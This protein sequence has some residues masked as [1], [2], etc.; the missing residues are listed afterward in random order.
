MGTILKP[1]IQSSTQSY[2]QLATQITRIA[3]FLGA[4]R[5]QIR[6][7]VQP[8]PEVHTQHEEVVK[9]TIKQEQEIHHV[10]KRYLRLSN[11]LP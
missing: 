10:S 8:Q 5:A 1:L 6:L 9:V 2:Q 11:I 7:I 3:D 4:P